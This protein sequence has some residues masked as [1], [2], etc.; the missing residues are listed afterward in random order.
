[1]HF[2]DLPPRMQAL[3]DIS[4]H[5]TG[6]WLWDGGLNEDGYGT[7]TVNG[8]TMGAHRATTLLLTG[9]LGPEL[10]HL[11]RTRRCVNPFHLESVSH[12]ENV[13]RGHG[14][15]GMYARR[16]H[17][18]HGHDFTPEN[19]KVYRH[20][21]ICLTCKKE[22]D[23]KSFVRINGPRTGKRGSFNGRAKIT[24]IDV[25]I[26]RTDSRPQIVIAAEYGIAQTTVSGIKLRKLW[27][28]IL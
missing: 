25:R 27:S 1:M 7:T 28:H 15:A 10:D 21:R 11:C 23:E 12:R 2:D 20:A 14:V 18:K 5:G 19:T 9:D 16:T 26:I 8:R 22:K 24:E 17:C 13:L 6:C 3:I 4:Q